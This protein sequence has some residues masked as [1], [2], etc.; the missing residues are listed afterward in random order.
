MLFGF[1]LEAYM[2]NFN[3]VYITL[4]FVFAIAFS[5]GPIG[6][7][8]IGRLEPKFD[9]RGRLFAN[10]EGK[11]YFSIFNNSKSKA[12]AI[13]LHVDNLSTPIGAINP[14]ETISA[15]IDIRL[16]KRGE[17]SDDECYLQSRFPLST[18]RFVLPIEGGYTTLVYPQPKGRPLRSFIQKQSM[19]FGEE[20]DFDGLAT[21]SGAEPISR[22]HWASVAKGE[23]AVKTFAHE[24]HTQRLIFRFM[25]IATDDEAR[26]SQLCLWVL[27][28]EKSQQDFTIEMPQRVL[29]SKKEGIDEILQYLAKY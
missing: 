25:D 19:H 29:E 8:N 24:Q 4:F 28:C 6:T 3:L 26:L 20:R 12:W 21:Y 7:F 11:L 22:I 16:P 10:I 1:F 14:K 17:V 2:H 27:E 23:I 5:A 13:A 9:P 15:S 18:V